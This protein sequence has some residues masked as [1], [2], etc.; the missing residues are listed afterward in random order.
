M[1]E[2]AASRASPC[3]KRRGT[4]KQGRHRRHPASSQE[5]LRFSLLFLSCVQLP[6]RGTH[7]STREPGGKAV[8]ALQ[9]SWSGS[10]TDSLRKSGVIAIVFLLYGMCSPPACAPGV[11]PW[12]LRVWRVGRQKPGGVRRMAERAALRASPCAKRRETHKQGRHRRH[13]ASSQENCVSLSCSSPAPSYLSEELTCP[14]GNPAEKRF[15]LCRGAGLAP[16]QT[17]FASLV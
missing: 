9:G 10:F 6:V 13:P 17:R 5:K 7:L 16:S 11:R 1:A 14:P 3:A 8:P 15:L 2:R 4:H 12:G